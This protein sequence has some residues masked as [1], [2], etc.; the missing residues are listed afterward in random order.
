MWMN[1]SVCVYGKERE[2]RKEGRDIK[3]GGKRRRRGRNEEKRMEIYYDFG[4]MDSTLSYFTTLYGYC[5][6]FFYSVFSP[7]LSLY[8][9][10]SIDDIDVSFCISINIHIGIG[11]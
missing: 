10:F 5:S 7:S 1:V 3:D 9:G 2:K 8:V 6:L 4:N 11:V